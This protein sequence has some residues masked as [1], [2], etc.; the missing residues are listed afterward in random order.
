MDA[1]V[2]RAARAAGR[3]PAPALR[4]RELATLVQESGASVSDTVLLRAL[5]ADPGRFRLVDP[6][7]GPWCRLRG[8]RRGGAGPLG[9]AGRLPSHPPELVDGPRVV[10]APGG[11]AWTPGPAGAAVT[12]LRQTMIRLGWRVD[13]ASSTDLARWHRLVLESTRVRARLSGG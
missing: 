11:T 5:A 12:R 7:K 1:L 10:P 6:W 3:H 8:L 4:L 13:L 9:G 2:E